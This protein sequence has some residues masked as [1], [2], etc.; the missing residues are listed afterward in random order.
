MDPFDPILVSAAGSIIGNGFTALLIFFCWRVL[1]EE[2][3]GRD[4]RDLPFL[5]WFSAI[6]PLGFVAYVLITHRP[7]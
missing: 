6:V 1:K 5:F 4:P 3:E 7:L 2:R